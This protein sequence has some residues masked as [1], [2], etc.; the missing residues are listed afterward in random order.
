M[1]IEHILDSI[2]TEAG[3]RVEAIERSGTERA[4]AAIAQA[5]SRLSAE[6]ERFVNEAVASEEAEIQRRL[7][8]AELQTRRD[9][10]GVR[11]EL[12][13]QAFDEAR[14]RLDTIRTRDDY[15]QLLQALILEACQNLPEP[16]TL[17]IDKRDEQH[18]GSAATNYKVVTDLNVAGGVVARS[19][20]GTITRSNTLEDRLTRFH[21][22][23]V[24]EVAEVLYS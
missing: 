11:R 12:F 19:A 9:L 17:H 16:I 4:Q 5:R 6:T 10:A 18:L 13:E 24:Y 1:P 14:E 3:N 15:P 7:N 8:A 2:E 23:S 22:S 21:H 20:D